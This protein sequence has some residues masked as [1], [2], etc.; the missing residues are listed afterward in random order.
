MSTPDKPLRL[1]LAV[2][3]ISAAGLAYQIV[4]MRVFAIGQ[5]HHF[6]Y[7]IISTAM[8]GFG[9]S[10]TA[11]AMLRRRLAGRER[12]ALSAS[13]FLFAASLVVCYATSQK[14]PFETFQLLSQPRQLWYLLA[15]YVILAVPFF[16][17]SSCVALAFLILPKRIPSVYCAN[18]LG[19]GL[20]ALSVVGLLFAAHPQL[21]PYVLTP[22][23]A[24][25]FWLTI[26]R[27]RRAR[28]G[29]AAATVALAALVVC[30][31][32]VP[33][34]LSEYK[35]LAYA[36]RLPDA[37]IV[38]EARSPASVITAV[39]SQ[40]IRET[41]GQ[42]SNY[43][44]STLGPLPEQVA[45]FFDGGSVSVS[46]RF[47]GS[48]EGFAYLDYVVSALAYRLVERPR[49]MVIGA[50]GGTDVLEALSHG[51]EHVT[52]VETDPR[53][54]SL[55][56]KALAEHAGGIYE[57]PDVKFVTAEGRGYLQSRAESY[58]LIHIGLLDS[59]SAS[60]AGVLALNESY[61]Y[62]R[63]AIGLYLDRLTARGVLAMTRWLKA[64][65]RDAP[66]LFATAVEACEERGFEDPARHLVLI[67][68]WNDA[69]VLVSRAPLSEVRIEAVRSFCRERELDLC[70]YPGISPDETNRFT[71]LEENTYFQFAKAVLSPNRE[72]AY[73]ESPFYVRPATDDRPYF[74]RFFK[75]SSAG[76]LIRLLRSGTGSFVEWGYLVLAACIVQAIVAGAAII[77]LPLLF[78]ERAAHPRGS[79][80]CLL[81]GCGGLGLG[82]MF[83]EIAFM[84][85][86]MLF[87]SYPIYAIAVVLTA[88][89]V[90]SGLGSLYAGR[91]RVPKARIVARAVGGMILVAGGYFV[92]LDPVF[93]ACSGWSDPA[94]IGL[95]MALL[96]PLA[97][98]MGIPFP[99]VLQLIS[100]SHRP[101]LPW[102]WAV[103]GCASVA[104]A[105]LATFIAVHSGLTAL[106]V[107]ALALYAMVAVATARLER[108]FQS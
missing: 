1:Y 107:G 62:T 28:M 46:N 19:S 80:R 86:F 102:A 96:A 97:F 5:W 60:A 43:P 90:F 3:T 8:L 2:F 14:V 42:I 70:Y 49:V 29:A 51:A 7:L 78:G 22:P 103:N 36:L 21:V 13:A 101:L 10:G 61:L 73:R 54:F 105:S 27:T 75:W 41:P 47:D 106:A 11:I 26:G 25:A 40:F 16:L 33:V 68:S 31:W 67:R 85:R 83:L 66:K 65:P 98:C 87:L 23:A 32:G 37:A 24:A 92:L 71:V 108:G 88:F 39:S 55:V 53:V 35:G 72:A 99:T 20:G 104:G 9:A 57:R 84:Q 82:Y 18:L 15:L 56:N 4:L 30:L 81:A 89:L 94:K 38:A 79:R 91:S 64:P 69:L 95:S 93:L 52:A 100:D 59:F 58:D 12:G 6:A 76:I 48:F 45:L 74:F 44:M 77:A 63:E 34:R 17:F 50:G